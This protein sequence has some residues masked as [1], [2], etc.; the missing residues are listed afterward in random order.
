MRRWVTTLTLHQCRLW[1]RI[2]PLSVSNQDCGDHEVPLL[3]L[4]WGHM[5]E[6]RERERA[7]GG[8]ETSFV[9]G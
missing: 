1:R 6:M 5:D 4:L 3:V 2:F 9:R 7:N 8:D